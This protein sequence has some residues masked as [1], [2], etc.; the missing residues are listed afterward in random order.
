MKNIKKVVLSVLL[1]LCMVVVGLSPTLCQSGITNAQST[2]STEK[3]NSEIKAY[4]T[5]LQKNI[6][7]YG[8]DKY[9]KM[10]YF[11]T[12]DLDKDGVKELIMLDKT[13]KEVTVYTYSNN[14]VKYCGNM[15]DRSNLFV[16]KSGRLAREFS[17]S[18]T[19]MNYYL[20]L[21]SKKQLC[22]VSYTYD[23]GEKKYY[24]ESGVVESTSDYN[25]VKISKKT[26]ENGKK[27]ASFSKKISKHLNTNTNRN[28][29]LR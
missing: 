10:N 11:A 3:S 23:K 1:S 28:K 21:N 17:N 12:L 15:Y 5:F 14:K 2:K 29:Y 4:K 25:R 18:G 24:K 16:D 26:Y 19:D 27:K 9:Y 20:T 7:V 8:P 22:L 13:N 6:Y